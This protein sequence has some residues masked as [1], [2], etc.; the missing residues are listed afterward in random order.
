MKN[1]QTK[2]QK[3]TPCITHAKEAHLTDQT[4]QPK[5]GTHVSEIRAHQAVY[6]RKT[7]ARGGKVGPAEPMVRPNLDK[8]LSR[9]ILAGR[10]F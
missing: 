5:F 3:I 7:V 8:H 6:Q 2:S 9:C 1:T 4:D 10:R